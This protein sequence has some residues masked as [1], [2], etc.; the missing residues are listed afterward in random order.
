MSEV[1][2]SLANEM[3]RRSFS[4]AFGQ[5]LKSGRAEP[6]VYLTRHNSLPDAASAFNSLQSSRRVNLEFKKGLSELLAEL[7][8]RLDS[9]GDL[10]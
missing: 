2:R 3:A 10:Q 8:K 1:I 6:T 9:D 5:E 4:L 7:E